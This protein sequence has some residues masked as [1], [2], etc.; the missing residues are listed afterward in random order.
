MTERIKI[1]VQLTKHELSEFFYCSIIHKILNYDQ[2]NLMD[3]TH[4][5]WTGMY[6]VVLY[7]H[8]VYVPRFASTQQLFRF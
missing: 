5:F 7:K 2:Y 3:Q 8:D 1:S 4:Q 6:L